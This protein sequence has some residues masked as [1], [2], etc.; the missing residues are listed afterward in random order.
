MNTYMVVIK[1]PEEMT[2]K[3]LRLIPQ[4]RAQIDK[5]MDESK[6]IQYALAGDRSQLWVTVAASSLKVAQDIINTFPL[7][8]YM[9][10]TFVELAFY[11][12]ISTELP[13]LI[14]N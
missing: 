8:A 5:L 7:R 9:Q 4:Q 10:P 1:L 11:N 3:F 13:K 12:S 2:E 14:M 6:I